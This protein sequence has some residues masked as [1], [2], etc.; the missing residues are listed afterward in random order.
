MC[1]ALYIDSGVVF[2]FNFGE[3]DGKSRTVFTSCKINFGVMTV[4]DTITN[5]KS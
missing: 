2:M 4:G 5:R 1:N 3:I